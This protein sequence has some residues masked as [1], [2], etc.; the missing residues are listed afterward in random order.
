LLIGLIGESIP[1]DVSSTRAQH[2][3]AR[4]RARIVIEQE[5]TFDPPYVLAPAVHEPAFGR[6]FIRMN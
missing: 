2:G 5:W 6:Q 4:R 3:C 1:A